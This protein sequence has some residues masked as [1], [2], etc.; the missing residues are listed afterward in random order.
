MSRAASASALA[1]V[2]CL[3]GSLY[4]AMMLG[5]YAH[6]VLGHGLAASAL[7]GTFR[8]FHVDPAAHGGTWY[9]HVPDRLE[10]I[11]G[12]AGIGVNLLFGLIA[13]AAS[14][15]RSSPSGHAGLALFAVGTTHT[16]QALGYSIQG[17]V[18]GGGDAAP[19]H[20][21]PGWNRGLVG[22]ALV[23]AYVLMIDWGVR[24]LVRL[25]DAQFAPRSASARRRWFLATA[26]VPF[27][28]LSACRP[29]STL[30]S[31]TADWASRA[32][33][34]LLV[35]AWGAWRSGGPASSDAAARPLGLR[36]AAAWLL[37]AAGFAALAAAWSS[38]GV[39]VTI[40]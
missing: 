1:F 29:A 12:W 33:L 7:G 19:L 32:A 5:C 28:A 22:A 2:G 14:R 16:G 18:S 40:A 10:W 4:A 23:V 3:L 21:L 26:L 35:G 39:G 31:A 11:P 38:K 30:F 13:I 15:L 36:G 24:A 6:E 20:A 8:G 34:V 25:I 17:A 37:V 9:D 27:A